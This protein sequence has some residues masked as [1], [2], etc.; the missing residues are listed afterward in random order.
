MDFIGK[1]IETIHADI[2]L[3]QR[4]REKLEDALK[5][6]NEDLNPDK[7]MMLITKKEYKKLTGDKNV[8]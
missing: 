3:E 6:Y 4:M 1:M 7:H 2:C 5:E 8:N